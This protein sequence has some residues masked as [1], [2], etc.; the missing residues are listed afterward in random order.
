MNNSLLKC[1]CFYISLVFGFTVGFSNSVVAMDCEIANQLADNIY[2]RV[3]IANNNGDLRAAFA[4]KDDFWDIYEYAADCEKVKNNAKKLTQSTMTKENKVPAGTLALPKG[5]A[6]LCNSGC[7]ITV[8]G[9]STGNI[10]GYEAPKVFQLSQFGPDKNLIEWKKITLQ[11]SNKI[12]KQDFRQIKS[13]VIDPQ[14][15]S[16]IGDQLEQNQIIQRNR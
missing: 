5:A 15:I 16:N 4:H 11:D 7:T 2:K 13:P 1:R 12:P 10:H 8:K 9:E 3:Y 14:P 6:A